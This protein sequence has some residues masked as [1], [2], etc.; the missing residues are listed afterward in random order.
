MGK[1]LN[2]KAKKLSDSWLSRIYDDEEED[3][4]LFEYPSFYQNRGYLED[5]VKSHPILVTCGMFSHFCSLDNFLEALKGSTPFGYYAYHGPS[6]R[7]YNECLTKMENQFGMI[8]GIGDASFQIA[9]SP[10]SF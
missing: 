9:K 3:G 8:K 5:E 2:A 7:N 4:R 10:S 6:I 1:D